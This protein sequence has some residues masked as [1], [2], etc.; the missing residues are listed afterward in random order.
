MLFDKGEILDPAHMAISPIPSV[1]SHQVPARKTATFVTK[2][3]CVIEKGIT[4]FL[5][6]RAFLVSGAT[7]GAIR[8]SHPFA[9][10]IVFAREVLLHRAVHAAWSDEFLVTS[11]GNRH[12]EQICS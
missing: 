1:K 9:F 8:H 5:K 11:V 4:L 12:A 2:L 10:H 3:K 7:S 6:K